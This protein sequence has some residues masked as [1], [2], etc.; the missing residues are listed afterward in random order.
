MEIKFSSLLPSPHLRAYIL[1][2]LN[3]SIPNDSPTPAHQLLQQLPGLFDFILSHFTCSLRVMFLK[4]KCGYKIAL[5]TVFQQ[6][7][8][9]FKLKSNALICILKSL[10]DV[11]GN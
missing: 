5:L 10:C 11:K 4:S 9:V 3:L 7:L 8:I 2:S 6:L 1:T